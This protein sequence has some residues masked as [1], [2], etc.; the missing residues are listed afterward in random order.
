[1]SPQGYGDLV[2]PVKRQAQPAFVQVRHYPA[3]TSTKI[4]ILTHLL[5]KKVQILTHLAEH[6]TYQLYL[7]TVPTA[8]LERL[9]RSR[10]IKVAWGQ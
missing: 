3:C 7:P 8:H 10:I 1:M 5:V 6:A 9:L 4:Q 2:T